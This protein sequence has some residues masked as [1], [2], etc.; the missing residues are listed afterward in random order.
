MGTLFNV[1]QNLTNA[2]IVIS[3]ANNEAR[4]G[5]E[6]LKIDMNYYHGHAIYSAHAG[7]PGHEGHPTLKNIKIQEIEAGYCGIYLIDGYMIEGSNIEIRNNHGTGMKFGVDESK[8]TYFGNSHFSQIY[9]GVNAVNAIGLDIVGGTTY[10]AMN[11][12]QFDRLQV[13]GTGT[14]YAGTVGVRITKDAYITFNS[15][16]LEGS[17]TNLLLDNAEY[18]T[19]VNPFIMSTWT[20]TSY[21]IRLVNACRGINVFGGI[22][23]VDNAAALAYSDETTGTPSTKHSLHGTHIRNYWAIGGNITDPSEAYWWVSDGYGT[24]YRKGNFQRQTGSWAD[25]SGPAFDGRQVTV[26]N[27]TQ[28]GYRLYTYSNGAWHYV[29]LT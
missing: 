25:P 5:I 8:T 3:N 11:L 20:E 1:T 24:G 29:A 28:G 22:L 13:G 7:G 15:P 12:A 19:I 23:I 6:G 2:C 18:I 14:S 17:I 10:R 26:Y 9:I 27:S 21:G 4:W 16:D